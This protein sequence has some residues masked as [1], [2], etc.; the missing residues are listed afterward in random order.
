M[1]NPRLYKLCMFN[2]ETNVKA[3]KELCTD[4][5]EGTGGTYH[6]YIWS[7]GNTGPDPLENHKA[8]KPAMWD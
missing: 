6:K 3:T 2:W 7:F 8:T 1:I 4:P 5:E